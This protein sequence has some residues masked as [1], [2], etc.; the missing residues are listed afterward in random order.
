MRLNKIHSIK[1]YNGLE[2]TI[3]EDNWLSAN[4]V[5]ENFN[6]GQIHFVTKCMI[7]D[8]CGLQDPG[9]R[10]IRRGP[11][12]PKRAALICE[13]PVT[14]ITS[15]YKRKYSVFYEEVRSFQEWILSLKSQDYH[16]I[17][18]MSNMGINIRK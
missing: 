10:W 3:F 15:F 4:D 13:P 7:E 14:D 9:D 6:T 5:L 18:V 8:A 2:Y 1:T 17:H 12:Q 16:G 11:Y